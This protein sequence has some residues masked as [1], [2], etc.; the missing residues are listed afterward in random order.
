MKFE[1]STVMK[2]LAAS[3]V[4]LLATAVE[5]VQA[6]AAA[7]P[8]D[9]STTEAFVTFLSMSIIARLAGWLVSKLKKPAP[10][11]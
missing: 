7:A 1:L 3:L 2:V 10:S 6:A 9:M 8:F 5:A 11:A 4:G